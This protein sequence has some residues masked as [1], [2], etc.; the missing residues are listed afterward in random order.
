MNLNQEIWNHQV[1]LIPAE[2]IASPEPAYI[3][4]VHYAGR[5]IQY[6]TILQIVKEIFNQ[7]F[8][9]ISSHSEYLKCNNSLAACIIE[10]AGWQEAV[11]TGEYNYS[12]CIK[13][14]ES[15]LPSTSAV[16]ARFFHRYF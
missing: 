9:L 1:L 16:T 14:N 4:K 12:Q 11:G 15:V 10:R 7:L 3:L 2:P 8:N 5:H 13:P 6:A